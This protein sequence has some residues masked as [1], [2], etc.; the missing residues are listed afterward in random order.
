MPDRADPPLHICFVCTG[1]ICRSPMGQNIF[2]QA[3]ADAGL[4]DRVRVD[5]CGTGPWH[6]GQPADRRAR[7][8]LADSGYPIDHIAAQAGPQHLSAD[9]LI[10]MDWGHLRHLAIMGADD[11]RVRLLRSFDPDARHYLDVDDPYNGDQDDFARVRQEIEAA[12]PG[13]LRWTVDKLDE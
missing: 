7:I 2:R 13:L 12:V 9:L 5:S 1:N 6:V 10:A 4:A 3:I 8:E 11:D